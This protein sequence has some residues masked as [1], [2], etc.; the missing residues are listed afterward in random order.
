[1]DRH[2]NHYN[3]QKVSDAE[4]RERVRECYAN[5]DTLAAGGVT[6]EV[7]AA[8]LPIVPETAK[9]RLRDLA[10]EG[11][12]ERDWGFEDAGQQ[13][14]GYRPATAE[15]KRL[16]TD[17]GRDVRSSDDTDRYLVTVD[18]ETHEG[19]WLRMVSCPIPH[20]DAVQGEDYGR[21]SSHLAAEHDPEDVG[22]SSDGRRVATDGGVDQSSSGTERS[23]PSCGWEVPESQ[24]QLLDPTH[25]RVWTCEDDSCRVRRF[26]DRSQETDTERE[27]HDES[28]RNNGGDA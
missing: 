20:C 27:D 17:G 9:G 6:A 5:G 15:E 21:F 18:S 4:L 14:L 25:G 23:C 8:D 12:L 13:R 28:G 3:T 26:V 16:V 2:P 1:M 24:S 22:L 19:E 7:V 11:D 10:D